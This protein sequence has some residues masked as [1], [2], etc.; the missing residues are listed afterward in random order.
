MQYFNIY[1][2]FTVLLILYYKSIL[3]NI[4]IYEATVP[5]RMHHLDLG[6]FHYQIDFTQNLI[7][8]QHGNSLIDEMITE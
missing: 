8:F 3:S 2:R 4:N 5:D 1:F 6:L 7:R